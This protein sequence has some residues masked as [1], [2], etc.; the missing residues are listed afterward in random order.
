[1][2]SSCAAADYSGGGGLRS[3]IR[4]YYRFAQFL[5]NGGEL[6]SARLLSPKSIQLMMTDQVGAN[7]PSSSGD[8]GWGFGVQVRTRVRG[9]E[10]GTVGTVGWGGGMGTYFWVDRCEQLIGIVLTQKQFGDP[11][12]AALE[13]AFE[14]GMYQAITKSNVGVSA[15]R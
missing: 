7:Y 11:H 3:T 9:A 10:L 12:A 2:P 13:D 8:Y 1:M 14:L 5:L 15:C 4:D 6:G